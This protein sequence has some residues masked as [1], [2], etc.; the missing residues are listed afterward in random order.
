MSFL[1]RVALLLSTLPFALAAPAPATGTYCQPVALRD[2]VV[3]VG[4]QAVVRAA[5]GCRKPALIRKESRIN[6]QA[7]PPLLVP[8]GRVQRVWLL[9]Y[10]LACST[11]GQTWRS[12]VVR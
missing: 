7:D 4:Y 3:V 9:T 2:T 8:V 6:R 11:D 10:R 12:L 5:P 1:I